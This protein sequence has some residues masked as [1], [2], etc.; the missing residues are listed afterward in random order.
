MLEAKRFIFGIEMDSSF[1]LYIIYN[2]FELFG[3]GIGV[4]SILNVVM[5]LVIKSSIEC[6]ESLL[7]FA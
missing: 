1:I 4:E 7:W 5:T 3:V 6:W 2:I